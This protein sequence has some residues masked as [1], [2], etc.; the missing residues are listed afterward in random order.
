MA[1]S[2]PP[3][4]RLTTT[5]L[6]AGRFLRLDLVEY[7]GRDGQPRR[8]EAAA[9][10]RD[11][12]A[13]LMIAVL[14]PSD[15]L[16]LI[17]QYRPP[18]D[19]MVLEFPA[20]LIDAGETAAAAA[21]RELRE[22]TGYHGRVA[23]VGPSSC[24]SPGMTSESV[25]LARLEVDEGRLE[26]RQPAPAPEDSEEIAVCLVERGRLDALLRAEQQAG[27]HLDSRLVAYAMGLG[28]SW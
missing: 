19:G 9:R 6:A 2:A 15:R 26:N 18:L 17:R 3:P 16:V 8:W 21:V 13:V 24:S 23:W 27:T 10:Q 5:T 28:L 22:E 11:V 20:G 7:R 25:I 12:G 4:R 14:K 1:P